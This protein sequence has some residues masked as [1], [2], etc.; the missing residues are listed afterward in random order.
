VQ[1]VLDAAVDA[2]HVAGAK[3]ARLVADGHRHRALHDG[4]ELLGVLVGVALDLLAGLVLHATEQDLVAA[5][6]VQAHAVDEL[7]RRHAV[8]GAKAR[9]LRHRHPR[10]PARRRR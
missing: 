8:P 5:D 1:L 6:R 2:D 3:L 4:H 9:A 7:E 10:R